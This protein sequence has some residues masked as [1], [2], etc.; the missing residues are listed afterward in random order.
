MTI[1]HGLGVPGC[2]FGSAAAEI[3]V[4]EL[5][6]TL[7]VEYYKSELAT[8]TSLMGIPART[9]LLE[10]MLSFYYLHESNIKLPEGE[11]ESQSTR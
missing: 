4:K 7:K 9:T 10:R 8:V 11:K 5:P 1:S 2:D 3:V 6:A